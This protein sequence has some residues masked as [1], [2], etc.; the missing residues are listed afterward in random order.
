MQPAKVSLRIWTIACLYLPRHIDF[1]FPASHKTMLG[2]WAGEIRPKALQQEKDTSLKWES[3][4]LHVVH[5]LE[6]RI[7]V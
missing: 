3:N 4:T 5:S 1:E 2:N 7:A 6:N